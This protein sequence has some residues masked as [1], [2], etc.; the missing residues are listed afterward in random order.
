MFEWLMELTRD[1]EMEVIVDDELKGWLLFLLS[2]V[3]ITG[4][5]PA[6]HLK[7]FIKGREGVMKEYHQEAQ[8]YVRTLHFHLIQLALWHRMKKRWNC[9]VIEV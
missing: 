7:Y 8:E 9:A 1:K 2:L 4:D 3:D 6:Q 5:N